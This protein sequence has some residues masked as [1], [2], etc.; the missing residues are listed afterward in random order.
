MEVHKVF[1]EIGTPQGVGNQVALEFNLI[2]RWHC[3]ISAKDE[4]W[5]EDF[6]NRI[7]PG[8]HHSEV[9]MP[10]FLAGV[11]RWE[12]SIASDPGE[13]TFEGLQRDENGYFKDDDLVNILCDSIEDVA[14]AF[15]AR[16]IP[17][18]MKLIE[19]LGIEQSRN[20][21]VASLNEFRQFF[22][23]KEHKTFED[24]NSDKDVAEALRQLYEDP[25]N[26]ELYPGLMAEEAKKNMVPGSGLCPGYTI[27]RAILSDAVALV[28]GDRFYTV[29]SIHVPVL[30]NPLEKAWNV[31]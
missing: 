16:N 20:W 24:I 21:Q 18:V 15:G 2:Y 14:G 17:V 19:V 8:K 26:V 28:R 23:L 3:A 5:T 22:G 31:P 4:K 9:G 11:R 1:S 29:V 25:N 13:R 10:E 6:Y 12:Q 30:I 27:S 7:F